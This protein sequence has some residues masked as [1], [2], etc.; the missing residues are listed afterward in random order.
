[1][2]ADQEWRSAITQMYRDH[3]SGVYTRCYWELAGDRAAAEDATQAT[4]LVAAQRLRDGGPVINDIRSWLLAVAHSQAVRQ[5][6][7][8][9]EALTDDPSI[10]SVS[11][12]DS[13]ETTALESLSAQEATAL[14]AAAMPALEPVNRQILSLHLQEEHG[15]LTRDQLNTILDRELDLKPGAVKK[16]IFELRKPQGLLSQAVMTVL[17]MSHRRQEC[18]ELQLIFDRA[19][20]TVTPTL[21]K[22]VAAHSTGCDDCDRR[23]R[24]IA[25]FLPGIAAAAPMLA[26]P[27]D[28]LDRILR[29]STDMAEPGTQLVASTRGSHAAVPFRTR[30]PYLLVAAAAIVIFAVIGAIT[31]VTANA[32][33]SATEQPS[34]PDANPV[35]AGESPTQDPGARPSDPTT[36]SL[37]A[38]P[39]PSPLASA[40]AILSELESAQR[41]SSARQT[42]A[43]DPGAPAT[44]SSRTPV[45]VP[46]VVGLTDEQAQEALGQIRLSSVVVKQNHPAP[47]GV[48]I[49]QDPPAGSDVP[50][51]ALI[52]LNVS[53]GLIEVPAVEGLTEAAASDELKEVGFITLIIEENDLAPAG[54]VLRHQPQ[55]GQL[56]PPN[57]EVTLYV[58]SGLIEVPD[59]VGTSYLKAQEILKDAD[60]T[61]DVQRGEPPDG[62]LE[63]TVFAQAPE[64]GS[65]VPAGDHI[66]LFVSNVPG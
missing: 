66:L 58:S 49:G 22:Q 35:P 5:M 2:E 7:R 13:S 26:P 57:T 23:R 27:P 46:D 51:G 16:R 34:V 9:E 32:P 36:P 20:T 53:S 50:S 15:A 1:M 42:P 44:V 59:V 45:R 11:L 30:K 52:T 17:M 21:R 33:R 8:V 47:T 29:G 40:A 60:L 25:A 10:G 54:T 48:V 28:L 43:Q 56:V 3:G 65:L 64:A 61:S 41:L 4:F 18:A 14:L 6:R 62:E 31:A 37:G 38:T 55:A 24:A 19:G 12:T 63:G 39:T